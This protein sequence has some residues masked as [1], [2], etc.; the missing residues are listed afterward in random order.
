LARSQ[1]SLAS[2]RVMFA[3]S[4]PRACSWR[5]GVSLFAEI[6]QRHE[7]RRR[8]PVARHEARWERV[9]D[10]IVDD[11]P[12]PPAGSFDVGQPEIGEDAV[13]EPSRFA[14]LATD[15]DSFGSMSKRSARTT[16]ADQ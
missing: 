13:L 11:A 7:R 2:R 3:A 4:T 16:T 14:W 10:Q 1:R 8:P 5:F 9:P 12:G 15:C 6:K